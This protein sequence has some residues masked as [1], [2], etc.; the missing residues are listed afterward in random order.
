MTASA[1]NEDKD[2]C[3]DAGMDAFLVS[4]AV[5]ARGVVA[6]PHSTVMPRARRTHWPAQAKPF[7]EAQLRE[8]LRRYLDRHNE[9]RGG[10]G[11]GGGEGDEG[12]G[13]SFGHLGADAGVSGGLGSVARGRAPGGGGGGGGDGM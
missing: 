9:H 11:G 13:E 7:Q 4:R 5:T 1:L 10:G 3:F 2:R 6:Q 8:V 12:G